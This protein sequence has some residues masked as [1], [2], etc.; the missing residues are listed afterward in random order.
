MY[1]G[2][3]SQALKKQTAKQIITLIINVF[4][5]CVYYYYM[6]HISGVIT[7][8]VLYKKGRA[9]GGLYCIVQ[10]G[11]GGGGGLCFNELARVQDLIFYNINVYQPCK[12]IIAQR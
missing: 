4:R 8:G 9:A 6:R 7:K 3:Q 2:T 1:A 10:W 12:Y 5:L 11:V